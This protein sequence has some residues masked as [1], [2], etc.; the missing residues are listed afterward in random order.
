MLSQQFEAP[1][2]CYGW[3]ITDKN[4]LIWKLMFR[5]NLSKLVKQFVDNI[6]SGF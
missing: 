5:D 4:T 3:V 2:A 1:K 6:S